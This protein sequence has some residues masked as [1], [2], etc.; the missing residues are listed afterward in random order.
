ME[1]EVVLQRTSQLTQVAIKSGFISDQMGEIPHA[2]IVYDKFHLIAN[3][4]VLI[5]KIRQEEWRTASKQDK[6][7]I[8]GQRYNLFRNP[9]NPYPVEHIQVTIPWGKPEHEISLAKLL[10]MNESLNNVYVLW[11]VQ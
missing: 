3:Y 7:F 11:G 4:N 6:T 2:E 5:D 9:E 1:K 8:K 10:S